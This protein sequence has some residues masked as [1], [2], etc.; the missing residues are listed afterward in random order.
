[1]GAKTDPIEPEENT[2]PE[3]LRMFPNES[4]IERDTQLKNLLGR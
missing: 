1:M 3:Y 4:E 2:I